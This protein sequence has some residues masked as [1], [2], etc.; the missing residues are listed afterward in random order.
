M[1]QKQCFFIGMYIPVLHCLSICNE[2]R[3]RFRVFMSRQGKITKCASS[4]IG[5]NT[6]S[7]THCKNHPLKTN[8]E[9]ISNWPLRFYKF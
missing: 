7:D 3:R 4:I 2:N 5:F 9:I 8:V 1:S 6:W